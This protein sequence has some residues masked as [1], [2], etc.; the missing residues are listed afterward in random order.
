MGWYEV[1]NDVVCCST[2]PSAFSAYGEV[3]RALKGSHIFIMAS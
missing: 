1:V 2:K 3:D